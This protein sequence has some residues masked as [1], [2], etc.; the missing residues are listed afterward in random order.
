MDS[1]RSK[2]AQDKTGNPYTMLFWKH[3]DVD[4]VLLT[5]WDLPISI[6]R[7]KLSENKDITM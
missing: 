3:A 6:L 7:V 4:I 5:A 1:L 2:R